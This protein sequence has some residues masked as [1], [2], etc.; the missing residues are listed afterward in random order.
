M[1]H[2]FALEETN[3]SK[4]NE[5]IRIQSFKLVSEPYHCPIHFFLSMPIP[6][7]KSKL[8]YM[9]I[10]LYLYLSIYTFQS[11]SLS[12]SLSLF[13]SL[14]TIIFK[15]YY[16]VKYITKIVAV[17]WWCS[18]FNPRTSKAEAG[19]SWGFKANL[20]YRVI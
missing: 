1:S 13:L 5:I 6:L 17:S 8:I 9:Y 10:Y 7:K 18:H 16:L 11:L 12:L 3:C 4:C 19:R 2:C 20:I 14:Q 15:L